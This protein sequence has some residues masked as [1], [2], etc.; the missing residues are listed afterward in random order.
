[1]NRWG[2]MSALALAA[3]LLLA[4]CGGDCGLDDDDSADE[5]QI[6]YE[7]ICERNKISALL[8]RHKVVTIVRESTDSSNG[9][10]DV[11]STDQYTRD[12]EGRLQSWSHGWYY[13][14]YGADDIYSVNV[15]LDEVPDGMCI[16]AGTNDDGSARIASVIACGT[17]EWY[18]ESTAREPFLPVAGD[19]ITVEVEEPYEQDGQL[20]FEIR[21]RLIGGD[22]DDAYSLERYCVDPTSDDLLSARM[23]LYATNE[24][25]KD[26]CYGTVQYTFDYDRPYEPEKDLYALMLSDDVPKHEITL[27]W[28][29]GTAQEHEQHFTVPS[30]AYFSP[31]S[32]KGVMLYYD[33]AMTQEYQTPEI[34]WPDGGSTT[35]YVKSGNIPDSSEEQP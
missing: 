11:K 21:T 14:E 16:I 35:V 31:E 19:G 9:G 1:M 8:E 22:D 15:C 10:Q 27:V 25:G 5:L 20:V 30:A 18:E 34:E 13:D 7:D 2:P 17:D 4:G 32:G 6:T 29:P 3:V 12:E 24:S 28:D 33:A 26:A 23:E